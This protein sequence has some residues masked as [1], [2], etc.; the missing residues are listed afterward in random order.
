MR[1]LTFVILLA[2]LL[3][4]LGCQGPAQELDRHA[5]AANSPQDVINAWN[6]HCTQYRFAT[7]EGASGTLVGSLY[8]G[9]NFNNDCD[10][11]MRDIQ[12][13]VDSTCRP[14]VEDDNTLSF[15]I[16]HPFWYY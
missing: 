3:T 8:S 2:V 7:I 4:A 10:A 9:S 1:T 5:S 15:V 11:F 16:N 13:E 12:I 14:S 6:L